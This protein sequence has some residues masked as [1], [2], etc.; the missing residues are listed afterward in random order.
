MVTTLNYQKM[1]ELKNQIVCLSA[2]DMCAILWR[3]GEYDMRLNGEF[4]CNISKDN[5]NSK[6]EIVKMCKKLGIPEAAY[7]D[8]YKDHWGCED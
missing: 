5:K 7:S 8:W 6:A 4:S 1:P 2:Y 3:L